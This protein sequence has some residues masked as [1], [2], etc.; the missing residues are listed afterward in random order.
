[1]S[2]TINKIKSTVIKYKYLFIILGVAFL[3]RVIGITYGYPYVFNIDEPATVRSSLGLRYTSE[4]NH[5]DWPHF[6]FYFNYFF[7]V[8][9]IKARAVLQLIGLQGFLERMFPVLWSDPFIFY[10]ISRFL[11]ALL[12]TLTI[13]PIYLLTR[14]MFSRRA[15]I[16]ASALFAVI[17]F[18]VYLSHVATPDVSLLFFLSWAIY[19]SYK[20]SISLKYKDIILAAIF[21]G[22]SS[23][24]KYNAIIMSIILVLF[25][26]FKLKSENQLNAKVIKNIFVKFVVFGLISLITLLATTPE[27]ITDWDIFWSYDYGRGFLWQLF[28]NSGPLGFSDYVPAILVQLRNIAGSTGFVMAVLFLYSVTKAYDKDT[29]P[30]EKNLIIIMSAVILGF[31][32]FMSRYSRSGPHYFIPMYS[33]LAVVCAWGLNKIKI[34]S[35]LFLSLIVLMWFSFHSTGLFLRRDTRNL[36]LEY[37]EATREAKGK[38]YIEGTDLQEADV[39]NNLNMKKAKDG[40]DLGENDVVLVQTPIENNDKIRL[41]ETIG[42]SFRQGPIIYV[43]KKAN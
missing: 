29:K 12:G 18:H 9:F 42:N 16:I 27:I 20:F 28:E 35:I 25:V 1:M 10:V 4:I 3:F 6:T 19:F 7:Y 38:I 40:F 5:F 37:Y 43:Y 39:I 31:I 33:L 13:I 22:I 24:I 32:L 21:F 23:G 30:Q 15:A 17:P 26:F 11:N 8:V 41:I 2:E 36:A 14:D 34:K